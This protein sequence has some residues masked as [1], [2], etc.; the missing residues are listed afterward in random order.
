MNYLNVKNKAYTKGNI[1][2][3]DPDRSITVRRPRQTKR[4]RQDN[5]R[6]ANELLKTISRIKTT[7]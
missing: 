1:K 6:R 3:S 7:R 4:S 5:A 2:F